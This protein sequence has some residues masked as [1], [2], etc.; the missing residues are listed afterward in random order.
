MKNKAMLVIVVIALLLSACSAA[1]TTSSPAQPPNRGLSGESDNSAGAP[2]FTPEEPAAAP[3][4]ANGFGGNAAQPERLVIKNATLT[5][6]VVDPAS[7]LDVVAAMA[8]EM[9]GFVVSSNLYKTILENGKEIPEATITVRVPAERLNEAMETIKKEVKDIKE[10]VLTENVSGQDVTQ[11]YTDLQSRMRNLEDAEQQLRE[12]LA[13]AT[14]TEDVLS[15]FNQLTSVREQIE[16]IK[17]QIQYFEEAAALSAINVTI[18]AEEAVQPLAIGGW[19][20]VGVARDAV[21][22]LINT[23]Q[24]LLK[25]A[26]WVILYVLP[27]LVVIYIPIRLLW[28]LLRRWRASRRPKAA[29]PPPAATPP[30]AA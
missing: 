15:T 10:D 4:A 23:L 8:D 16:V 17:G 30:S 19:Q 1:N 2:G 13:S 7:S 28:V 12:I 5:I 21:Q 20:P 22:A 27:V 18:K 25:A 26:I 6:V 9:G 29:A 11:E 3:Q 14:R 24:F